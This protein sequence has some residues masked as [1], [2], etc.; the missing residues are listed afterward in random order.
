MLKATTNIQRIQILADI[1]E[2]E[3]LKQE[4]DVRLANILL[5]LPTEYRDTVSADLFKLIDEIY[6]KG[7][8][9]ITKS[10]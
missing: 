10:Q 4:A 1:Y 7:K 3:I 2:K 5:S 8:K 6:G 9:C